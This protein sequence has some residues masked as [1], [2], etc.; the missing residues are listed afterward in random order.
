MRRFRKKSVAAFV[1]ATIAIAGAG[2]AYA[3]WTAGGSGT[4]TA[5]TGTSQGLVAHQTSVVSDMGPGDSPQ[6]LSGN[7][8]NPNAGPSH[9][10]TV[11][12]SIGSI[13]QAEDAVGP[14]TADDYQLVNAVM[15][16]NAE[17]PAGDA[18]GAWGV[19]EDVATIQFSNSEAN[20]DGCKGATV[21][22]EYAIS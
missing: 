13:T 19:A 9:V 6:E 20:Q 1:G 21:H 3:Y 7:F 5:S 17:I 8:D 14:C 16:V 10:S 11:T 2:A 15:D 12:A 22:L 4:G 18:Q